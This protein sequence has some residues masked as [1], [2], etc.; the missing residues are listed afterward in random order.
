VGGE[1]PR[2]S[3]TFQSIFAVGALLFVITF[4]MNLVASRIVR[5]YR[6]EY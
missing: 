6:Q 4:A 3:V 5:R 1:S 2:G